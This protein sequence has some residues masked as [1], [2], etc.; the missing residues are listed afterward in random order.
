M[1]SHPKTAFTLIELLVVVAIIVALLAILLP[2]LGSAMK[3][4]EIAV[5]ASNQKQIGTAQMAYL[6][7]S[8]GVFPKTNNW[9]DLV[10]KVGTVS[11][12]N[13][14]LYDVEDR[15]L[16]PYISKVVDGDTVEVERCPSDLGDS[17]VAN[18]TNCYEQYGSSYLA[19]WNSNAFRV[20]KV[21]GVRGNAGSPS[22]TLTQITSAHNKILMGDWAWHGNRPVTD[23]QTRWHD[24]NPGK[25]RFNML[26]ADNH[27]EFYD[28]P[29]KDIESALNGG[30]YTIAAPDPGF[31]W[32]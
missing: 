28:F 11:P 14:N 7:D 24:P 4:A 25:R 19:Q 12:Y 9:A 1:K 5:C 20:A 17:L 18:I 10:G 26:F 8:R 32:W 15:P 31:A 27:V 29:L 23:A 21:Y 3:T 13:S 2:S 22:I 30:S 6:F 16:N